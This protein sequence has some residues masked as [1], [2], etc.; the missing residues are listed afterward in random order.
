DQPSVEMKTAVIFSAFALLG[1][2][3]TAASDHFSVERMPNPP[4]ID[5][6]IGGVDVLEDGRIVAVFHRGEVMIFD[7]ATQSWKRFA[8]GLH[9][10]LGVI[11]ESPTSMLVM[12][13]A[14]LTRLRDDD[15]DGT[16]EIYE[17][18]FDDFGMTG[19]YHEFAF[20]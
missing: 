16:A 9:E 7:P 2:C 13:R 4:G 17:T 6:Q 15:G 3:F 20:G 8:E 14:E 19:N 1:T 10:P 12:Q 5:P 18:V 11:A